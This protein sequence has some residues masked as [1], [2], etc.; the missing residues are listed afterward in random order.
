MAVSMSGCTY[1]FLV[2]LGKWMAGSRALTPVAL[3]HP[4]SIPNPLA[5]FSADRDP[6]AIHPCPGCHTAHILVSSSMYTLWFPVVKKKL[7]L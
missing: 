5:L 4:E 6:T 1:F 2:W 7:H 3:R